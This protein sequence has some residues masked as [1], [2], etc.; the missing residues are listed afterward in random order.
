MKNKTWHCTN[1]CYNVPFAL[2]AHRLVFG[3]IH[4]IDWCKMLILL[5]HM[6]KCCDKSNDDKITFDEFCKYVK[7]IT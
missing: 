1:R 2:S 7:T 6:M 4:P 5:Q 3:D